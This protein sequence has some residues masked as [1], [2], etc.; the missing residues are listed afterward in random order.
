MELRIQLVPKPPLGKAKTKISPLVGAAFSSNWVL[1]WKVYD[2]YTTLDK[3]PWLR[4]NVSQP[5][6][7]GGACKDTVSASPIV[8]WCLAAPE[9]TLVL[10]FCSSTCSR[11]PDAGMCTLIFE[12][13]G[14]TLE[15]IAKE[16]VDACS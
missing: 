14:D 4:T 2:T 10:A 1:F 11:V 12:L 8:H 3:K 16:F 5:N 9:L 15:D 7:R 13:T 6:R